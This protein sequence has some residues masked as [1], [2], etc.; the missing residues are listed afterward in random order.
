MHYIVHIAVLRL[1]VVSLSVCLSVCNVGDQ[2][3]KPGFLLSLFFCELWQ[4]NKC[5][6][7]CLDAYIM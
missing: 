2:E 3:H 4:L 6:S 1:H 7:E 5:P